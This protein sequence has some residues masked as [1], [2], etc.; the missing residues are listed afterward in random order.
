MSERVLP[1]VVLRLLLAWAALAVVGQFYSREIATALLPVVAGGV[2]LLADDYRP[3]LFIADHDGDLQIRMSALIDR[4]V[5]IAPGLAVPAGK[6]LPVGTNVVHSLVPLVILFSVLATH[7]AAGW[8]ERVAQSLAGA[9]AAVAVVLLTVPFVLAGHV[10]IFF[11]ELAQHW[12][13]DRPAPWFL[14]WMLAMES[15]G[16]WLVGLVGALIAA[17]SAAWF[18]RGAQSESPVGGPVSGVYMRQYKP[19][20][21]WLAAGSLA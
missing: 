1:G 12:R 15:G 4:P 10:E 11:Q 17:R 13:A 8:R 7:S 6:E 14:D 5:A 3:H 19:P 21:R 2:E 9:V 16:R 20:V 18:V